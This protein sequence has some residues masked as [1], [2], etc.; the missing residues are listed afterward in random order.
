MY[1]NVAN[2]VI[3]PLVYGVY[4]PPSVGAIKAARGIPTHRRKDQ[5][6]ERAGRLIS[7]VAELS[8]VTNC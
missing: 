6:A 5:R 3:Q 4:E 1:V 7:P 8:G 2:V